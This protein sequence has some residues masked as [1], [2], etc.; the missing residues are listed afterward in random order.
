MAEA[1]RAAGRAEEPLLVAVSKTQGL[2]AIEELYALGQR[3]FGENYVQELVEKAR[4]LEQ[5]GRCHGIRWHFIGHL[6]SNKAK[7]LVPWVHVV[8]AVDSEKLAKELGRRWKEEARE[9]RLP[10]FLEVNID[11]EASKA[12]VLPDPG[13]VRSLAQAV[14]AVPELS[15]EGL[16]C[17]PAPGRSGPAFARMRELEAACH[18]FTR[19]R[20]SMGMTQDYEE[21]IR[22]GATHIRVGTALFGPRNL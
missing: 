1:A 12:G 13:A 19:G 2:P 16:M 7:L 8:H 3:D 5:G 15:C 21:A 20:L 10:V 14:A 17:I 9:G 4:A 11:G 22:A 6:Q 18:A